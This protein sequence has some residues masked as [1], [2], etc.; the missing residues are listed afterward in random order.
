MIQD[1]LILG[2]GSAGFL[3]ALTLKIK[4]PHLNV[5]VL[6]SKE[7][8]IIGVGEGTTRIVPHHLHGYLKL[9]V[10]EFYKQAK[11]SW[12]L[13]VKFLWGPRPCYYYSFMSQY[14]AQI[15]QCSLNNGYFAIQEY[16]PSDQDCMLMSQDKV[17]VRMQNGGPFIGNQIAYHLENETFVEWLEQEAQRR[18]INIQDDTVQQVKQNEQGIASLELVSGRSITADLFVDCSG[19]HSLLLGQTLQEP[20]LSFKDSL[21]CNSAVVGGWARTDRESIKPYTTAETMDSGWCWQIEHEERINRGYVYSTD[22]ISDDA[23]EQEFR[24]KNPSVTKTRIVRF[25]TGRHER[26]W[27][28]NVVAIGNSNGFVEPLE[29]TALGVI[30]DDAQALA[31]SLELNP[32][33]ITNS[34]R[35]SYNAR[36]TR[37]WN[38]IRSFL[39]LHYKFNTRLETPFWQACRADVNLAQAAPI[40]EFF[41]ENGPALTCSQQLIDVHDT[42]QL[43]GYLVHLIGM[44][45]PYHMQ[46]QPSEMDWSYWRQY[47][48]ILQQKAQT[49]MSV[50]E[51]LDIIRLPQWQWSPEFY[52]QNGRCNG[53]Q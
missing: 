27:V 50:R 33:H 40:A 37:V 31:I 38:C 49:A 21:F 14:T 22:F 17:F 8:G 34:L 26:A 19:F 28:K 29:A 25:K 10:A 7:L 16:A 5:T 2:G 6:R 36:G 42:F 20:F 15:K 45:V 39:A 1:I 13:G 46:R 32:Q 18:G 51:A 35:D 41:Q 11:P 47:Q 43:D 52:S 44:Q 4:L 48:S 9:D 24:R 53:R 30:C 12:K 3:A 23:A